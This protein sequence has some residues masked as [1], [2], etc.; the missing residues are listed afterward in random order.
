M[1]DEPYWRKTDYINP[2]GQDIPRMPKEYVDYFNTAAADLPQQTREELW[3][4]WYLHMNDEERKYIR[5]LQ[6]RELSEKAGQSAAPLGEVGKTRSMDEI[7]A[8]LKKQGGI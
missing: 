7:A 8:M 6:E 1:S 3:R 4:Q 5:Q 2:E